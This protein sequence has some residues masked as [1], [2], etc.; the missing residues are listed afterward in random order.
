VPGLSDPSYEE[1]QHWTN[2]D[3]TIVYFASDRAGSAALD[4]WVATRA[5]PA[6]PFGT[7]VRVSE[8][9][10][11]VD[12]VDPWLSPDLH[13]MVFMSYRTGNG[14]LYITTR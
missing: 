12:D 13:T 10:T 8:L 4:I 1:S 6:D 9:S 11:A 2:P 7:P 14:D 5:S 3:G